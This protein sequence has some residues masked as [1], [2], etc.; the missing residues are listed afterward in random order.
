MEI[1]IP[2]SIKILI[3]IN[4]SDEK[5][6]IYGV[7]YNSAYIYCEGGESL[8]QFPREYNQTWADENTWSTPW[9]TIY[10]MPQYT[11]DGQGTLILPNSTY[12]NVVRVHS[13]RAGAVGLFTEETYTYYSPDY[14]YHLF[15]ILVGDE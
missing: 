6:S 14:Q 13:L 2:P 5:W 11:I 4:V 7:K 1:D 9:N 10:S 8:L 12:E 15:H 3:Y